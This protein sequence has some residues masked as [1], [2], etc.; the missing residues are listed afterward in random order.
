MAHCH[1]LQHAADGLT[2]HLAYEGVMTPFRIG[3]DTGNHP[4]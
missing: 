3:D 4:E 1:N 2:T